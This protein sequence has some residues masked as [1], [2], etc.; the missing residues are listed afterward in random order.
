MTATQ[1]NPNRRQFMRRVGCATL[2]ASAVGAAGLASST[3]P[4]NALVIT[5]TTALLAG[6]AI[7]GA[8][9]G[10]GLAYLAR[11]EIESVLGQGED[12]SGYTGKEALRTQIE[13]QSLTMQTVDER[14]FTSIENNLVNSETKRSPSR[15]ERLRRSKR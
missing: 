5:G 13:E 14:V 7:A 9:G 8:A 15:R 1:P 10:A 6:G 4:A 12:L 3:Q 2:G 11:D